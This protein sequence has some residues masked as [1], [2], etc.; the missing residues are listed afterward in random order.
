M[1]FLSLCL[2]LCISFNVLAA[3]IQNLEESFDNFNYSMTVEWDQK[4]AQFQ[5][6]K[7][8][9]FQAQVLELMIQ[10]GLSQGDMITFVEKKLANINVSEAIKLKLALTPQMSPEE[11]SMFLNQHMKDFYAS[12]SSWIGDVD[13]GTVGIIAGAVVLIGIAVWFGASYDCVQYEFQRRYDCE[14]SNCYKKVCTQYVK[15]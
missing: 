2:S 6:Q 8:K 14:S 7:T 9:E 1:K 15:K 4:D 13:W 12:G 3:P 11:L 5:E 10:G